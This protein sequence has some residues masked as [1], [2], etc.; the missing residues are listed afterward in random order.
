HSF[1]FVPLEAEN[2][3]IG[4]LGIDN[5]QKNQGNLL[6]LDAVCPLLL[7][8]TLNRQVQERQAYLSTHD[9]LTGLLNRNSFMQYKAALREETLIS[10]GIA[11]ININGLRTI[12]T[13]YSREFGDNVL[14]STADAM[15]SCFCA[16]RIHRFSGDEFL[17][18]CENLTQSAFLDRVEQFRGKLQKLYPSCASIGAVWADSGIHLDT[19]LNHADEH[20]MVEKQAYYKHSGSRAKGHDPAILRTL[21]RELE[22]HHY[23]M[24]L[25]PKADIATGRIVGA[26]ALVRYMDPVVGLLGPNKFV[27]SLEKE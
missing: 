3:V 11:V 24:Y 25:Q 13:R 16:D 8:E 17:A 14:C 6:L 19:L 20:M 9:P 26:E 23:L 10:L 2:R 15:C 4:Y 21:L 12:N 27:P 5:P 7:H 18:V 22:S 1:Y